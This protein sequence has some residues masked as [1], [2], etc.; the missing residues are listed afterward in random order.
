MTI[1]YHNYKRVRNF[2]ALCTHTPHHTHVHT[3]PP[4]KRINQSQNKNMHHVT[5]SLS[6]NLRYS[7]ANVIKDLMYRVNW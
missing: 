7:S 4:L 1:I 3:E 6:I 2:L 5:K